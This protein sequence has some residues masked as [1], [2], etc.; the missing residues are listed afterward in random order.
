MVDD[1]PELTYGEWDRRSDARAHQLAVAGVSHG[2]RVVLAFDNRRW[3]EYA[4]AYLAVLKTGAVAVPLSPRFAPPELASV[5]D[6]CQPSA[7]VGP[8]DLVPGGW[9]GVV[10]RS[11]D[12]ADRELVVPFDVEARPDDVAEI[13]YTSGTT[14][15]PKGVACSHENILAHDL[16]P[17]DTP[18]ATSEHR[19]SFVHAFPIGT[20]AGQEV[21]RLPLRRGDRRAIVLATF[22]PDRLCALFDQHRVKRLQLV[23]AMA[24]VLL[25]SGAVQRHDLSSLERITLSSAP[26]PPTL[27]A[28]LADAIPT[29]SLWNA[30][31]LTEAGAARTLAAYDPARPTCV[32]HPVGESEV[33]VLADGELAQVGQVGLIRL[34]RRDSPSRWYYRDPAATA[35]TFVDGWVHTG[36]V[37]YLDEGGALFLVDRRV[38]LIITGGA[39]VSS[40]EVENVLYEHPAVSEAAVFSWPH[41]VLGED[42]AAAV[43][44]RFPASVS[45]LQS[46]VRHRLAE[47]KI[48]HRVFVVDGLPRN[49]SG[50]VLKRELRA[51]LQEEQAAAAHRPPREATEE[52]ICAIWE[53]IL[54]LERVGI[55]DDFFE[56]GG[57]SLAGV[58]I[59]ARL[60]D[61][62]GVSLPVSVLFEA[63]TVAELAEVVQRERPTAPT[64]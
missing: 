23:P 38:D 5:L 28:R 4:V 12:V 1:G 27:F 30:Y 50:K 26:T 36:D 59:I 24:Q 19:A 64:D 20:N 6:H 16:P 55:D 60:A 37:G 25:D 13:L 63:P 62:F 3:T 32:G 56:S 2:D 44:L 49:A 31:A 10:L 54:G 47:H 7:V 17:D 53:E 33:E 58:Q 57:H 42:V 43:V 39:N 14:G 45:E 61:A 8:P 9:S 46:F 29:A 15:T 35:A 40:V 11:G 52:A 34:R 48:P 41:P 21:L 18:G 22:D 51:S